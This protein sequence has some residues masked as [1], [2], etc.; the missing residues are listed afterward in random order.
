MKILDLSLFVLPGSC[1]PG[2]MIVLYPHWRGGSASSYGR[3]GLPLA[4]TALYLAY[5]NVL[6]RQ[7]RRGQ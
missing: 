4:A 1:V 7:S 2:A 3:Y 5:L 6:I